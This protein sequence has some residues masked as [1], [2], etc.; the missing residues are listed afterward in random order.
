[1]RRAQLQHV[2]LEIGARFDLT[3]F[4][5]IGS[6]ALLAVLPDPP[7]GVLVASRDVGV[8]PGPAHRALEDRLSFVLG[9]GSDFDDRY[10][11]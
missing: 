10:G 9:E 1:M 11:Y 5:V 4:Y 7:E 2:I 3:E 8:I 6:S